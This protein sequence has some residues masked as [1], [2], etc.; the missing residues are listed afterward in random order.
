[1][2][3]TLNAGDRHLEF[4]SSLTG[5]GLMTTPEVRA[6]LERDSYRNPRSDGRRLG[7]GYRAGQVVSLQVEARP[8]HR[9]LDE[10]W[11]ELLAVWRADGVRERPGGYATLTADSGRTAYGLP[12]E[13]DPDQQHHLYQVDRAGLEFECM[14]DLWYGPTENTTVRFSV[15]ETGG[16]TFPAEAPF[17]FDSGPVQRNGV[18]VVG[19]DTLTGPR[20]VIHGPVLNPVV[21]VRGVGT[22]RF[23]VDLAYDQVLIAGTRWWERWTVRDG[24]P[25]PG[26]LSP[27]GDRLADMQ[28]GPGSYEVVLTGYDPSGTGYLDVQVEPAFTS[29]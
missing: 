20:F 21:E 29:P 2:A 13:L 10:V 11:R 15:P 26:V 3:W 19:G 1:M 28:L 8:D 7:R 27:Q 24:A 25:V 22:L 16:L 18:L 14:D 23:D 17:T 5:L 9:P 6:T 4:G 12:A